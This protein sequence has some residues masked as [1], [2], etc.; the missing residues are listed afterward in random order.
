[1]IEQSPVQITQ[2]K[3]SPVPDL[4]DAPELEGV[5]IN[6]QILQSRIKELALEVES[7]LPKNIPIV[8]LPLLSGAF[9]FTA[10]LV[11][12]WQF[13]FELDFMGLSSYRGSTESGEI[14][15]THHVKTDLENKHVLIIDDILDT[16]KT[17]V[18]A[19]NGISKKNPLSIQTCVLLKK[20][21]DRIKTQQKQADFVGFAIPDHF[22]VGYG[23]DFELKFRQL[24][25]VGVLSPTC[26]GKGIH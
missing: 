17:I 19:I 6:E 9:L 4:W 8:V 15:W 3:L 23:L 11:R 22:V 5:L 25:F 7:K 20:D 13:S 2:G 12:H 26:Y 1:M 21:Q 14:E 24:P 16:G 10:D 18:E